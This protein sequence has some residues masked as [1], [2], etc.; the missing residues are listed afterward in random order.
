MV[1]DDEENQ[2]QTSLSLVT[3]GD[4]QMEAKE[5]EVMVPS[6]SFSA[7]EEAAALQSH[8]KQHPSLSAFIT[9]EYNESFARCIEDHAPYL[10]IAQPWLNHLLC[11]GLC[12]PRQLKFKGRYLHVERA[13]EPDQIV[14]ESIE[15]SSAWKTFKRCL[16]WLYLLLLF[17]CVYAG[18]AA[19]AY[20]RVLYQNQQPAATSSGDLCSSILPRSYYY[21]N[22]S[23]VEV[24]YASF[25]FARSPNEKDRISYDDQ[26]DRVMKHSYHAI[27]TYGGRFEE[28]VVPYNTTACRI[29]DDPSHLSSNGSMTHL[30]P[31]YGAVQYC[32]CV[33]Q[34]STEICYSS[35][36]YETTSGSADTLMN[37]SSSSSK[38]CVQFEAADIAKCFCRH[39]LDEDIMKHGMAGSLIAAAVAE[40]AADDHCDD[41]TLYFSAST[42]AILLMVP[43]TMLSSY[44]I[45]KI[46]LANISGEYYSTLDEQNTAVAWRLC[47][48]SYVNYGLIPLI[49]FGRSSE[50]PT[51]ALPLSLLSLPSHV[52][53]NRE[54][55]GTVGFYLV[56]TFI[57]STFPSYLAASYFHYYCFRPWKIY[58]AQ[59]YLVE[60][61][62]YRYALQSQVNKVLVDETSFDVP[63]RTGRYLSW[64]L[65]A[66][67]YSA[68]LP[69]LLVLAALAMVLLLRMDR[70]FY[71]RFYRKQSSS[72][73]DGLGRWAASMLPFAAICKL[74]FSIFMLSSDNIIS[75]QWPSVQNPQ[76]ISQGAYSSQGGGW[77]IQSYMH[78]VQHTI[79]SMIR[80]HEVVPP[81]FKFLL[82]HIFRAN[83]FPLFVLLL[84]V[85]LTVVLREVWFILP[86]ALLS[87]ALS[88]IV[89]LLCAFRRFQAS[90]NKRLLV[91]PYDLTFGGHRAAGDGSY[92]STALRTQEAPLSGSYSKYLRHVADRPITFYNTFCCCWS[93][94]FK[95]KAAEDHLS[96]DRPLPPSWELFQVDL[97]SPKGRPPFTAKM[98]TWPPKMQFDK[99]KGGFHMAGE[100]KSTFDL[101][102]E[103]HCTSYRIDRIP[104][105]SGAGFALRKQQ[106]SSIEEEF[107]RW[108]AEFER[109]NFIIGET[110]RQKARRAAE[111][112]QK[113]DKYLNERGDF[114]FG[115]RT[116]LKEEKRGFLQCFAKRKVAI[117]TAPVVD[118]DD[119]SDSEDD[120]FYAQQQHQQQRPQPLTPS[121]QQPASSPVSSK[122]TDK[123]AVVPL[124]SIRPKSPNN[125]QTGGILSSIWSAKSGKEEVN[126]VGDDS[127]AASAARGQ[128]KNAKADGTAA[129]GKAG[130]ASD[131][132]DE[133]ESDD[134]DED[135][136]DDSDED[137][138][139]DSDEDESDDS[140]DSDSSS[141]S[142][143]D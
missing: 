88:K 130:G 82:H 1:D 25:T 99:G 4:D 36:C 129:V 126:K 11:I 13:P 64:V 139:N 74:A 61:K 22:S 94:I 16:T 3:A 43:L 18:F 17:A 104:R 96:P 112:L 39:Q 75:D 10:S 117:E 113:V 102:A 38:S 128:S 103:L 58:Y 8:F 84:I 53:F 42:I 59:A 119:S 63:T 52:E 95:P 19:T 76:S 35:D 124:Q 140:D 7:K 27:Y 134:S 51:T 41:M 2:A 48:A 70:E 143:D 62:S 71:C 142:S 44:L 15:V 54:W 23:Q 34:D 120:D 105:Y 132:S 77:T 32:P 135:E 45:Q 65:I 138:S 55:Y 121:P 67:T 73:R 69:A 101:I 60:Q 80:R 47:I 136:S 6:S 30:C 57:L 24:D 14:W 123:K 31:S 12:C 40:T 49:A 127:A 100:Q 29:S 50:A 20:L 110:R 72:S 28:P 79:P 37:A 89:S 26:C 33:T 131:N 114:K 109:K 92:N 46:V 98:K 56:I 108:K 107:V 85:L 90:E 81:Q 115:T 137:E 91:H 125:I 21:P 83:T 116:N 141:D 106:Y 86:P 97:S 68:G 133:D 5:G 66:M 122:A 118:D 78:A 87:K 93:L 9:F 111:E